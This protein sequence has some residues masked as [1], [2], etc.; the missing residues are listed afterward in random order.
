MA[1]SPCTGSA[2]N[3]NRADCLARKTFSATRLQS[4]VKLREHTFNAAISCRDHRRTISNKPKNLHFN[5]KATKVE[6]LAAAHQYES[7]ISPP[8]ALLCIPTSAGSIDGV[9]E[10]GSGL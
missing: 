7:N 1:K 4:R 5:L 9:L 8:A 3:P 10:V 6:D 2:S